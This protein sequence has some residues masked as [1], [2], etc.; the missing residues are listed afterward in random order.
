MHKVTLAACHQDTER[1][2]ISAHRDKVAFDDCAGLQGQSSVLTQRV[3]VVDTD[4]GIPVHLES[5]NTTSY[6][7]APPV[8]A[9]EGTDR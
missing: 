8:C 4:Y 1:H 9:M 6:G 5:D 7:A 2:R 3:G